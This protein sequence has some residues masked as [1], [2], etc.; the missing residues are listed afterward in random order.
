VACNIELIEKNESKI[1]W[2]QSSV[3]GKIKVEYI[4]NGLNLNKNYTV[5]INN[6]FLKKAKPDAKGNLSFESQGDENEI[7]V[8]AE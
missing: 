2:I 8:K 7:I 6:T 3:S 4:M 1:S 5:F